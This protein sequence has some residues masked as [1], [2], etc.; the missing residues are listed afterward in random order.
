MTTL[1]VGAIGVYRR[2][3]SPW[4]G[5]R[6][7]HAALHGRASCSDFGLRVYERHAFATATALMRRRFAACRQAYL[8][9][10]AG[11]RSEGEAEEKERQR[12]RQSAIDWTCTGIDVCDCLGGLSL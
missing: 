8:S 3:L 9:L 4:K 2:Y 5:F 11:S 1:A 12:H 6:C 10:M 7:A